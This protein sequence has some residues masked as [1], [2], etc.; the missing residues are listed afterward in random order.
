MIQHR[1]W[2][3]EETGG[4]HFSEVRAP[5]V[6]SLSLA[7]AREGQTML[8]VMIHPASSPPLSKARCAPLLAILLCLSQL[9]A[10]D[11]FEFDP[12][13]DKQLDAWVT[14]DCQAT[15]DDGTLKIGAGQ[16]TLRLAHELQDFEWSFA[17][18]PQSDQRH[19]VS[20][21]LRASIS[22]DSSIQSQH[23]ISLQQGREGSLLGRDDVTVPAGLIKT[24]DWNHLRLRVQGK[25][26][27]LWIAETLV[28]T[29][30]DL[31]PDGGL[32]GF[33]CD[34]PPDGRF[35]LRDMRLVELDATS[36]LPEP[37]LEGW[38]E[39]GGETATWERDG[40]VLR[41]RGGGS[42]WLRW[43]EPMDDLSLRLEYR[44]PPRGNS[45]VYLRVPED[46]AHHGPG[47]GVEIQ[48]LD[49]QHPDYAELRPYQY[50][51]GLYDFVG[52]AHS[53]SRPAGQWNIMEITAHQGRYRIRLNGF[54]VIDVDDQTISDLAARRRDGYFGLQNHSEPVEFRRVRKVQSGSHA[55]TSLQP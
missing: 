15:L 47:S 34:L 31:S 33:R 35:E 1:R 3:R 22:D 11:A 53:Y 24:Q 20:V 39:V 50:S 17:W 52:P 30:D 4:P 54:T 44:L 9:R 43:N 51:A 6:V 29:L 16:G 7:L 49:D 12:L 19:Q 45:G 28:W 14:Q 42:S 8:N 55:K 23:E 18:R 38:T 36:L 26:A 21:F 37:G 46:G 48:I 41:C 5:F 10:H 25:T 27:Q 2:C 32:I 13:A 40:Q